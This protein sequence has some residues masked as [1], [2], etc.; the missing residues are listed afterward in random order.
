MKSLF[1]IIHL[2]KLMP[3]QQRHQDL[4]KKLRNIMATQ[5]EIAD[6]LVVVKAD[7]DAALGRITKIGME[8]DTLLQKIKDLEG[9]ITGDASPELV[10]AFEAVKAQATAVNA[11]AG[12]VDDKVPDSPTT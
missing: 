4:L 2:G 5:K 1:G 6:A 10:A 12:S 9:T 11:A 8:T 3:E 7:L